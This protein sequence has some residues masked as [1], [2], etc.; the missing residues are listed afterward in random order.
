MIIASC[1]CL[2]GCI[3]TPHTP[4]LSQNEVEKIIEARIGRVLSPE[5]MDVTVAGLAKS[6]KMEA[7]QNIFNFDRVTLWIMAT[8]Y[9]GALLFYPVIWRPAVKRRRRHQLQQDVA[10]LVSEAVERKGKRHVEN[11]GPP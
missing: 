9:A 2:A 1:C 8:G 6:E 5:D 10:L 11:D 4:I 7:G 3:A